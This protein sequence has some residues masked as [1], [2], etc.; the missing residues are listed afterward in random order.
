MTQIAELSD[1]LKISNAIAYLKSLPVNTLI[2]D[3]KAY[4]AILLIL[5]QRAYQTRTILNQNCPQLFSH[6]LLELFKA[7]SQI[8]FK[9]FTITYKPHTQIQLI[10]PNDQRVSL[11]S[12]IIQIVN[13]LAIESITFNV[14]FARHNGLKAHLAFLDDNDI[15]NKI[16]DV[17]LKWHIEKNDDDLSNATE[18]N[19]VDHLVTNLGVLSK[20]YEQNVQLW[21]TENALG[22]L[23]KIVKAN[24]TSELPAF[25]TI[26]N[27]ANDKQIE[28]L[29]ELNAIGSVLS[30]FLAESAHD[31][32]KGEIKRHRGELVEDDEVIEF[33]VHCF[34]MED[35]TVVAL[36]SI[37]KALYKL[38]INDKLRA[39][40]YF[41][42][43]EMRQSLKVILANGNEIEQ[44]FALKLLSQL[45]FN[46]RIGEDVARDKEI[47]EYLGVPSEAN[48][49]LKKTI[50]WNLRNDNNDKLRSVKGHVMIS[51]N[52]ASRGLC[53]KIKSELELVGHKVY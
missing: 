31:F 32:R 34:R 28:S 26:C 10:S 8:D 9:N 49:D 5:I 30:K 35:N 25:I 53:L 47:V 46:S 19:L 12:F 15:L 11:I 22:I 24:L 6:I 44:K 17:K 36:T 4:D 43:S 51:Y 29:D 41:G 16:Y 18:A 37:I 50:L 33:E 48:G 23:I 2:D 39:D 13:H 1:E 38:C 3:K 14:D 20:S 42:A 45:T 7:C 52:S 21:S 40:I 27:I